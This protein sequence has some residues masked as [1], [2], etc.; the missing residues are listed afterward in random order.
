MKKVIPLPGRP[1]AGTVF[2]QLAIIFAVVF[3]LTIIMNIIGI[4][5]AVAV[6]GIS[7]ASL[8]SLNYEAIDQQ[9][10]NALK[11]IQVFSQLGLFLIPGLVLPYILFRK[12]PLDFLALNRNLKPVF[13]GLAIMITVAFIPL[14]DLAVQLNQRMD[15]PAF[16]DRIEAYMAQMEKSQGLLTERFLEMNSVAGLV[17]NMVIIAALAA[18]A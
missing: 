8:A 9:T 16:L 12:Q 18:I 10:I 15:L 11:I 3:G 7:A 1:D 6:T 4:S 5:V 17:I 13:V 2:M 14:I